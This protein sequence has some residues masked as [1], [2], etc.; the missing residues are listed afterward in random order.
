MQIAGVELSNP[1]FF[2]NSVYNFILSTTSSQFTIP[3]LA[4]LGVYIKFP[5]EYDEIWNQ[6]GTPSVIN[7]TIGATVYK[8][9]NVSIGKRHLFGV[10]PQ[11]VF[12]SELTFSTFN[13]SFEF[14]NPNKSID[15]TVEP[16]FVVSLFNFKTNSIYSQSLSNREACPTFTT[17]LYSI[18]VTGNTKIPAG[19]TTTFRVTLEKS[20]SNL[21][22][23][24]TCTSSAISFSPTQLI[25]TNYESTYQEFNISA[26]NG[27]SGS[28]NVT[29][30]KIEG[31]A[32]VFYSD[33]QY[34]TLNVYV[35]TTKYY[36][37]ITPFV[38][39]SV[40]D[41]IPVTMSLEVPSPT[42]FALLFTHNCSSGFVFKPTDRITVP[43]QKS[44][45]TFTVAYT[46][47]IVPSACSQNFTISSLTTNNYY[48]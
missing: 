22:I 45:I 32:Y 16:V 33:I 44:N 13:V 47:S 39:K 10:F 38:S 28:F 35:P 4:Q 40:G 29:F 30:S 21:T 2:A 1:K 19:S 8:A 41:P 37:R 25:F 17:Y 43:A 27:L 46:G 23:V 12:P 34:I 26:A 15:C 5:A 24:P 7:M 9:F 20:A 11:S 14:R 6:I 18:N 36:I 48:L 31:G 3:K 42:A